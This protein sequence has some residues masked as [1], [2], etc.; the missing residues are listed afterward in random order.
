MRI[1]KS[2]DLHQIKLKSLKVMRMDMSQRA[3][4]KF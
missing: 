2:L 1:G 3:G 4:A